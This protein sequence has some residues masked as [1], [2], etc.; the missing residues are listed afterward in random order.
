M[1]TVHPTAL[2]DES[3][4][5]GRHVRVGAFAIIGPNVRIGDD[6]EIASR[7]TI[8]CNTNIDSG[9]YLGS[10]A[11]IGS[12]PQDMKFAGE[13]TWVEIGKATR[14]REYVTI[15]RGTSASK[16]TSIGARCLLMSYVHIAHDCRIGDDVVLSNGVQVGGHVAIGNGATIGGSTSIHQFVRVGTQAFIGGGS[17]V[18]R[19][20]APYVKAAGSPL[21]LYGTNTV[22]LRRL[23]VSAESRLALKHAYRILFNSDV[24]FPVAISQLEECDGDVPE[25]SSLLEFLSH[26]ARGV[27][28]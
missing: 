9:C 28:R 8:E 22:G 4:E 3:A 12:D 1:T 26:S 16:R 2:M 5:L 17:H 20:V 14:I 13:T 15:N 10:G 23:G 21:K 6:T 11:V 18:A 19:D 27:T 24:P 25:V 7:V